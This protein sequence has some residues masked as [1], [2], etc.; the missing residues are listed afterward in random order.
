MGREKEERMYVSE[1]RPEVRGG[2]PGKEISMHV[3]VH[4]IMFTL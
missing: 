2:K 3:M 1:D 4:Q